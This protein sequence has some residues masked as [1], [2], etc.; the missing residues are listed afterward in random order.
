M[1]D[2]VSARLSAGGALVRPSCRRRGQHGATRRK[3][4]RHDTRNVRRPR[5]RRPPGHGSSVRRPIGSA[6]S[7]HG[8]AASPS[9]RLNIYVR[10]P[11]RSLALS[12]VLPLS[13]SPP[14]NVRPTRCHTA[15]TRTQVTRTRAHLAHVARRI[16]PAE[17]RRVD[18][19]G[20]AVAG[21]GRAVARYLAR[22]STPGNS[23]FSVGESRRFSRRETLIFQRRRPSSHLTARSAQRDTSISAHVT[24]V[25]P[26][27]RA[28]R[29]LGERLKVDF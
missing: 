24:R 4:A 14:R 18:A 13:R 6:V 21:R 17:R 3:M 5:H 19:R 23:T 2:S 29:G 28:E 12:F 15:R 16:R 27:R 25:D 22:A 1:H 11:A 7:A 8:S 20:A 9:V 26:P 10:P